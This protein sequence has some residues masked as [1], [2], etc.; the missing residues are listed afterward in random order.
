[1]VLLDRRLTVDEVANHLQIMK[2][3]VIYKFYSFIEIKVV[4]LGIIIIIIIIYVVQLGHLLTRS[5]L[6][7]SEASSKVC[8]DSFC[9]SGSSVSLP[10]I[11]YYEAFCLHVISSFS[12]IP[13]ICPKLE[14]FLT[15]F[16]F[17]Y[18]F[19]IFSADNY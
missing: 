6:T 1:M 14:L 12:C 3:D 17:V 11:I 4:S 2:N 18:L 19:C 13:V 15:P 10:W 16:Q 9:Q 7:C 8:H 5:G